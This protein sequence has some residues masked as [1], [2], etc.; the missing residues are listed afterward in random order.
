MKKLKVIIA[1]KLIYNAF[2]LLPLR[3]KSILFEAS[4]GRYTSNPKY[5]YEQ[6]INMDEFKDWN[7]TWALRDDSTKPSEGNVVNIY[8][9]K[10]LY[11]LATSQVLI[12]DNFWHYYMKK[13]K[14][15]CFI[16]TWHGTPLKKVAIDT[17]NPT[18]DAFKEQ[19]K[20]S[21]VST[22]AKLADAMLSSSDH[23]TK[24]IR[25]S[26]LY[27]GTI[28]EIGTP[29]VDDLI[30]HSNALNTEYSNFDKVIL[31]APSFR[32][33]LI[34][35][36]QFR[37]FFESLQID[38]LANQFP[39]YA[40]L[41]KLHNYGYAY[42]RSNNNN[43]IDVSGCEDINE[44]YKISDVLISDYSSALFDFS[45]MGKT[46]ICY[47]FDY[48]FNKKV[49]TTD[50]EELYFNIDEQSMPAFVVTC[51][52]QLADLLLILP[53]KPTNELTKYEQGKSSQQLLNYI[54]ERSKE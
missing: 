45:V 25:N 11:H 14:N 26:F 7:I 2:T 21:Y 44:L 6:M 46:N 17:N 24:V 54:L 33:T 15:Q 34:G 27:N 9:L 39:S 37:F 22:N 23:G 1:M 50:N 20:Q 38:K 40:F 41:I 28:L 16:Q 12:N 13:R 29:R 30:N 31:I 42:R 48:D 43:I 3:K 36:D 18:H 19:E 32:K 8:S 35:S 5:L 52:E 47:P 4:Q 49:I 53:S 51:F 10:Y